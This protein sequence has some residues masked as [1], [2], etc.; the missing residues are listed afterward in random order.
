MRQ[1]GHD[2]ERNDN[3]FLKNHTLNQYCTQEQKRMIAETMR[4]RTYHKGEIIFYEGQPSFL[5]YFVSSGVIKLWKEGLHKVEQII[6]FTK[7]GD[8]MGFWGSLENKNYTLSA[9][10]ITDTEL[11]YI[12]KDI[13]LPVVQSNS[14]LQIMLHDYIRELKK[15]EDELRNM[16]DMNVREK[17]AHSLLV[18]LEVFKDHLDEAAY[19]VIL[20]RKEI[21]ALSAVSEDRVGKQL[22]DF[23]K[24]NIITIRYNKIYIDQKLLQEII[25]PYYVT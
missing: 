9:T 16:G 22:A 6:R 2:Y 1:A 3:V 21:A 4:S 10:A 20:S 17:V 8:M 13:F 24:D 23:K 14:V 11:Y 25:N 15:T 18:L 19:R 12:R 5:I 7:E